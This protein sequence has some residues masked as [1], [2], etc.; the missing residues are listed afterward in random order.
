MLCL[1]KKI[2][3]KIRKGGLECYEKFWKMIYEN[4]Y[5]STLTQDQIVSFKTIANDLSLHD[6]VNRMTTDENAD[7]V[8]S[9][10]FYQIPALRQYRGLKS[11][12]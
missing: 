7:C 4:L 8:K 2:G 1:R 12:S 6:H 3:E 11:E 10:T 9:Q 5:K